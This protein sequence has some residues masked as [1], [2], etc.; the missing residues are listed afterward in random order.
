[1]TIF[2]NTNEIWFLSHY[3]EQPQ[4]LFQVWATD[5]DSNENG[6][7]SYSILPPYDYHFRI[8][9]NG[10]VYY[11]T[12]L[13]QS[14][15][16]HVR[17]LASDHGTPYRLNATHDC[18]ISLTT[19]TFDDH[20]ETSIDFSNQSFVNGS[21]NYSNKIF[22]WSLSLF[23]NYSL[24]VIGLFV[25]FLF[26]ILTL[27]TICITFCLHAIIFSG[28][29]NFQK[30]QTYHCTR[31]YHLYDTI[32]RKS[33]FNH[34]DSGR[35]STKLDD[36]DDVISEERE[37][38]VNSASDQTSCESSESMNR[39]IKIINQVWFDLKCKTMFCNDDYLEFDK[40]STIWSSTFFSDDSE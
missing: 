12:I 36:H 22:K 14:A 6:R 11:S 32:H 10:Q 7:I 4:Y 40:A 39:Q 21:F 1:M 18:Y 29:K 35:S 27:I 33:P 37:R 24:L 8:N 3:L 5:R 2:N 13:N 15:H 31:Q 30:K 20:V 26:T 23:D 16:F 38:L 34:D 19:S 28:R 17:I 9:E 25:L